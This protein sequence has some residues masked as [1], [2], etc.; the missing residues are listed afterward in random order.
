MK[1]LLSCLLAGALA[2]QGSQMIG[3]AA[4]TG[5]IQIGSA[6]V[7]AG[8]TFE[9]PVVIEQNPGVAA[10]SLNLTYDA[11]KL[12]LLGA[13]DGEIL[14]SSVFL[15]GNDMTLIPYTMNWDDLAADNN[16][17]TGTVA[18]LKFAA[19]ANA[20]GDAAVSVA[21]NQRSTFNVDLEE[22]AFETVGGVVSIAADENAPA[23]LA[24]TVSASAGDTVSVPLRIQNNPG[25]AALSLQISY[26][27]S[28]LKLLGAEDGKILGSSVFLAGNDL[29]Q[30]PY[31]LNWDDLSS[32]N[33]TGN[34][35]VAVLQ[36]EVLAEEGDA[37]IAV[38]VNQ[39][40]TFNVDLEEV[41]FA[42]VNGKVRIGAETTSAPVVTTVETSTETTAVTSASVT[43]V[44]ES[45]TVTSATTTKQT[46]VTTTTTEAVTTTE[47]TTTLPD[48]A[49]IL[50]DTVSASAG[51]TVS[52]PLRIQNNP[53]IAALSLQI[54]YDASRLKLLGAEDGKILGSS[55]FLAGNDLT[56]IPYTLNWDDLSSENNTGNGIV[57]VLQF[58][59]LA[60]EG[61]AEIAVTVNQRS[62]F[63]VD[64]EEVAFAAVNGKVRIRNSG[65]PVSGD[66]NGD[67][68]LT[69]ADTV[70]LARFTAEDDTLTAEQIA[71]ILQA[72]PDRDSSGIVNY[73]DVYA[74]L[75]QVTEQI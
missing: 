48:G 66:M 56:Q 12:E 65:E 37:E 57:A 9:L 54:S 71:G 58:E 53:G 18:V 24:D 2:V 42:A 75:N 25:I 5:R 16:T 10:L 43:T 40:S 73:T 74:L 41:A 14:G 6:S 7:A 22:V 19:K 4:D 33:N 62:T 38:T 26:D 3:S 13:E 50:A 46:T 68:M 61:D 59:V 70:L 28:R 39:R 30:I 64:L 51:D 55:V 23:I 72:E 15:A 20:A 8:E 29:T 47:T 36:F 1:K 32:E 34:G 11:S 52:V 49:A 69:M 44:S 63:N 67:G 45:S 21:V 17:G 35:I 27:A 31:T 60:E